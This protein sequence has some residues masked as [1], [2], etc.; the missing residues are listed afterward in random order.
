MAVLL[1]H[2]VT[3]CVSLIELRSILSSSFENTSH[4]NRIA[5][6]SIHAYPDVCKPELPGETDRTLWALPICIW[7]RRICAFGPVAGK[8]AVPSAQRCSC[9][10]A[11]RVGAPLC[12][13]RRRGTTRV[14]P[15]SSNFALL[16]SRCT[17]AS[18]D[19]PVTHGHGSF[20]EA[21]TRGWIAVCVLQFVVV[22]VC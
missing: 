11:V 2:P 7:I 9:G 5:S 4:R 18:G 15:V 3:C 17:Y 21:A 12:I 16:H 10:E 20:V 14:F 19:L 22:M 8:E 1:S 13:C 6:L